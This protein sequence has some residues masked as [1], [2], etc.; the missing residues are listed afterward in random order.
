MKGEV[1]LKHLGAI[2]TREFVDFV[3]CCVWIIFFQ[4][5]VLRNN[6]MFSHND[7]PLEGRREIQH[8]LLHDHNSRQHN[9]KGKTKIM[10]PQSL[11]QEYGCHDKKDE[12]YEMHMREF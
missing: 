12:H 2:A 7:E 8:F 1:T 9:P 4:K 10:D 11:I 5:D 6:I 3:S